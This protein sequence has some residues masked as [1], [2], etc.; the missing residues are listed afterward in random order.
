MIVDVQRRGR[1]KPGEDPTRAVHR[2]DFTVYT[3]AG[4]AF[5]AK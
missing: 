3:Q 1:T 4:A 5:F 2:T